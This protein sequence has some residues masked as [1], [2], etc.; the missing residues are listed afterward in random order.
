MISLVDAI[1]AVDML[2]GSDLTPDKKQAEV[3]Y[4]NGSMIKLINKFIVTPNIIV[5]NSVK[6]SKV[7]DSVI[8]HNVSLFASLYTQ[9]FTTLVSIHGLKADVAFELLS[10]DY[11]T[12]FTNLPVAEDNTFDNVVNSLSDDIAFLPGLE[13]SSDKD[14]EDRKK[15]RKF[16]STSKQDKEGINKL[17]T[18][19]IE[20]EIT[21]DRKTVVIP[22]MIRAN[23]IYTK[24]NNIE[25]M[26]GKEDGESFLDRIDD[27]RAGAITMSDLI[28][29]TDLINDYK[30]RRISDRDDLIR[31]M[32]LRE[33]NSTSKFAKH[34]VSGY[35]KFYQMMVIGSEDVVRIEKKLRGSIH[36]PR[37]KEAFLDATSS[38]TLSV[39]DNDYE[40]VVIFVNDLRGSIDLSFNEIKKKDKKEE[41]MEELLKV[42]MTTRSL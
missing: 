22:A 39:I 1:K 37:V 8:E 2:L 6:D 32:R 31:E 9:V 10:S 36:K 24:F 40:R 7:M 18:R 27:Y 19:E 14:N 5:S 3:F 33:L 41:T 15:G 42:L 12:M 16:R 34:G 23:V 11:E 38:L 4:S 21:V 29:A 25:N 17:I 30:K 28:F 13:A 20:I 26:L 35:S